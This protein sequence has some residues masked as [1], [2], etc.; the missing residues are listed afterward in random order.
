MAQSLNLDPLESPLV[1]H[2]SS[3]GE[4]PNVQRSVLEEESTDTGKETSVMDHSSLSTGEFPSNITHRSLNF[5][6]LMPVIPVVSQ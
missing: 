5:K 6:I 1:N 4:E 3:K 2:P